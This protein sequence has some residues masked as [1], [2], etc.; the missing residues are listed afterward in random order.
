[1][2]GVGHDGPTERNWFT[3]MD[4][5]VSTQVILSESPCLCGECI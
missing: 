2:W 4:E 5:F 3:S 1:V